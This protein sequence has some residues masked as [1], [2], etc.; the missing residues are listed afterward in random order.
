M[1]AAGFGSGFAAVLALTVGGW[2]W[3]QNQPHR[4]PQ[5]NTTAMRATFKGVTMVTGPKPVMK[6]AYSLE[7]TTDADYSIEPSQVVTMATVPE[8][9]GLEVDDALSLPSSLFIPARQKVVLTVSKIGEYSDEY[10]E[11][12]RNNVEKLKPYFDRR[13]KE[14]DGFVVFDKVHRY[15]I[16]LP[17]GW[18]DVKNQEPK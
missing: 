13:L 17:N 9:K 14:V 6:F 2:A 12:E 1:V 5:W 10:P 16:V 8:G 3:Y 18:P 15:K 11:R 7:N 4:Q